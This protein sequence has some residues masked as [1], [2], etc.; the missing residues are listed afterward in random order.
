MRLQYKKL[1]RIV[2]H[3]IDSLL[4]NLVFLAILKHSTTRFLA[5]ATR[6]T[7]MENTQVL[8]LVPIM[9]Y[10]QSFESI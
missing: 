7:M 9:D 5:V 10:V 1:W 4:K 2:R 3:L 6:S 8:K